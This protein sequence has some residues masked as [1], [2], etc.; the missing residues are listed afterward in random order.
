M[1]DK[2]VKVQVLGETVTVTFDEFSDEYTM[3]VR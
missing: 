3:S 1:K 2:T